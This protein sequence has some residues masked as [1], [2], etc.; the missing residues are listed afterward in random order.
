MLARVIAI[1]TCRSVCLSVCLSVRPSVTNRYCVKTKKNVMISLTS[2]SPTILVFWC[3]ISS[4]NS[5][6]FH[7]ARASKKGGMGK[8]S[9]FLA[10][11]INISISRKRQQ[12]QPK[13]LLVTTRKS[14]MVFRLTP[15]SMTL[16]DT[17]LYEFEFSWNF[18]R[19]RTF[20]RQ[21][22]LNEWMEIDHYC[23]RQNWSLLNV[24]FSD[25]IY[26]VDSARRSSGRR[27]QTMVEWG[28][29]LF[30]S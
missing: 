24:L 13:L 2:G 15:I 7:R 22:R 21:Q 9:D 3:Q 10:L 18:A 19:F 30:C 28:N 26:Y 14:H 29:R 17:E 6:R 12:I 27:R 16:D 20:G 23:Q 11:S 5:K 25:C 1:A 8:F 4:Q